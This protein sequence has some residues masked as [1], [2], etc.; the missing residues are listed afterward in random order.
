MTCPNSVKRKEIEEDKIFS[1]FKRDEIL[2]LVKLKKENPEKY[3]EML[4]D[5]AG[6]LKD[7]AEVV[8]EVNK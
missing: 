2:E 8:D 6:V 3:R 4:K 5:I 7:I 1:I